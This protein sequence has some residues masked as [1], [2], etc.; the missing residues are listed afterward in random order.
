MK[1]NKIASAI[2]LVAGIAAFGAN[3]DQG[4]GTVTFNGSIIDAPCSIN[5]VS[6]NQTVDLGQV[7]VAELSD[8][9]TSTPRNFNILLENCV[10]DAEGNAPSVSLTFGGATADTAK[11]LL[12]ITGTASGAGVAVTDGAGTQITFG[13]A[14]PVRQLIVG[15]NTLAFSAY[16]QGLS[17][18]TPTEGSFISVTDFTLDY[19]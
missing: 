11:K 1:L 7:T 5:P 12:G 15:N 10:L 9:K 14:T 3:A 2:A 19:Q 18:A 6:S 17:G 16:M 4:S 8:S 13:T